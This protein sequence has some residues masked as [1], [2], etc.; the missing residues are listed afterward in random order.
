MPK[1]KK[2]KSETSEVSFDELVERIAA[3]LPEMSGE[4]LADLYNANFG[5]G[6]KYVGND[7]FEQTENC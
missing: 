6:M 7:T 2:S 4:D 3:C 1:S 5:D